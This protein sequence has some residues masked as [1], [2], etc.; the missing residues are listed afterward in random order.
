MN[1]L[2]KPV[3]NDLFIHY[4]LYVSICTR[5]VHFPPDELLLILSGLCDNPVCYFNY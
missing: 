1:R 3:F 5:L 2:G 4:E